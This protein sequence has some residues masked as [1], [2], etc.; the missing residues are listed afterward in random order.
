MK[1]KTTDRFEEARKQ[2]EALAKHLKEE[3]LPNS[4]K[5]VS[6]VVFDKAWED[7]HASGEGEVAMHYS[8]LVLFV[9]RFMEAMNS[10][11]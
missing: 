3:H 1:Q 6:D 10:A 5:E 7:G 4:P 2:R 11:K 9:A 8:E